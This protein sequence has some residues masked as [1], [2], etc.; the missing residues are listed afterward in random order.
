MRERAIGERRRGCL[1]RKLA[2]AENA[3]S[4]AGA[5]ALGIVDD[6]AAPRHSRT[7]DRRRNGIDDAIFSL[8]HD[9]R[10]QILV[11]ELGGI[12]R[13]SNRFIRHVPTSDR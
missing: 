13:Q 6:D 11:A 2:A 9:R 8:L 5:G 12:F 7:A 10:L 3:A 1:H 4:P